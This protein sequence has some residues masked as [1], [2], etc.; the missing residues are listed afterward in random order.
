MY[1]LLSYLSTA[2]FLA[3]CGQYSGTCPPGTEL[4][5]WDIDPATALSDAEIA[6]RKGDKRL[7]AVAGYGLEIPGTSFMPDTARRQ[8]GIKEAYGS[9][10]Y[11]DSYT[12]AATEKATAYATTYNQYILSH[13]GKGE[14]ASHGYAGKTP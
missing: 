3:S 6:L 8:Y 10:D 5:V 14:L 1:K 13:L 4:C 11:G 2:I 7:V 9:T 12:L